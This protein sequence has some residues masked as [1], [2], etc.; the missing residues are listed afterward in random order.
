VKTPAVLT[1]G[2]AMKRLFDS[3]LCNASIRRNDAID[4]SG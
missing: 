4:L 2:L 1:T 3:N